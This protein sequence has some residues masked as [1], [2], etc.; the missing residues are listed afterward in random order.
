[1]ISVLD[2]KKTYIDFV[3]IIYLFIV[4]ILAFYFS[5]SNSFSY[6]QGSVIGTNQVI[7]LSVLQIAKISPHPFNYYLPM[8]LIILLL[9]VLF[10]CNIFYFLQLRLPKT[11]IIKSIL[12]ILLILWISLV[13]AFLNLFGET[14]NLT[15]N[16][17]HIYGPQL[18]GL[19]AL[20]S[21]LLLGVFEVAWIVYSWKTT[22]VPKKP[23]KQ[24]EFQNAPISFTYKPRVSKDVPLGVKLIWFYE[25]IV[26]ILLGM[27]GFLVLFMDS[28][29]ASFNN[30]KTKSSPLFLFMIILT[31]FVLSTGILLEKNK[32][33]GYFLTWIVLVVSGLIFLVSMM[34]WG[35]GWPIFPL[36]VSIVSIIYFLTNENFKHYL[37]T[38]RT[39]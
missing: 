20:G 12:I 14:K 6:T 18:F 33:L 22:F 36:V 1:M 4:S 30:E 2:R 27:F 39:T 35:I 34:L 23:V 16:N 24:Q 7:A 3:V 17:L 32:Y 5:F 37:S 9:V 13:L 28:V 25:I 8:D 21:F 31:A 15:V 19:L 11:N 10:V 38:I 29:T 26:G